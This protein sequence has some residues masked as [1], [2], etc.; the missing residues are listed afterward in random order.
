[1]ATKPT[2]RVTKSRYFA[3]VQNLCKTVRSKYKNAFD[4][5]RSE[6]RNGTYSTKLYLN[7]AESTKVSK[8]IKKNITNFTIE[9]PQLNAIY[10]T[11]LYKVIQ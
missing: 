3:D 11:P 5:V 8:F 7:P 9:Q 6:P 4:R 10:I 2:I 1:M